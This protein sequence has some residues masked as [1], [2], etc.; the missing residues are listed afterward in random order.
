MTIGAAMDKLIRT[1]MLIASEEGLIL[2][3][4]ATAAVEA[5]AD[6]AEA[7]IREECAERGEAITWRF[8]PG[9]GDLPIETQ[10]DFLTLLDTS[11]KIGLMVSGDM[12]LTP[13]K[14]VTAITG[15]TRTNV[16]ASTNRT[17]CDNCLSRESCEYRKTGE[18][19]WN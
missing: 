19:C 9:Y 5:A 16:Q 10:A 8:S 14:S 6:M 13:F 3:S 18:K 17:P 7:M 15:V 2:D 11:R 1:K 4:C 12:I